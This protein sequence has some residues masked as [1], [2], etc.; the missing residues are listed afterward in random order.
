M[1]APQAQQRVRGQQPDAVEARN[2]GVEEVVASESRE[3][4]GV[5]ADGCAVGQE[6]R[7]V[8]CPDACRHEVGGLAPVDGRTARKAARYGHFPPC[9]V[10]ARQRECARQF[11]DDRP[12]AGCRAQ[13]AGDAAWPRARAAVEEAGVDVEVAV[14]VVDQALRPLRRRIIA[15]GENDATAARR[16]PHVMAQGQFRRI[17]HGRQRM[18]RQRQQARHLA[19][20][21]T[22]LGQ[23]RRLA[24]RVLGGDNQEEA[25][26]QQ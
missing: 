20:Q 10:E 17:V 7:D 6:Q 19:R 26:S 1:S 22:Q 11:G 18:A 2:A 16:R 12:G 8:R 9:A 5:V 14:A 25:H 23:Q 13:R 15:P 21:R 4:Q 24:R 3:A